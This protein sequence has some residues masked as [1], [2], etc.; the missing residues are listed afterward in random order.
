MTI[1]DLIN[2]YFM[3]ETR[4]QGGNILIKHIMDQSLRTMEFP[5]KKVAG[6]R[7]SH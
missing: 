5:T 4:S 1:D 3:I 6:G 2:E 7:S